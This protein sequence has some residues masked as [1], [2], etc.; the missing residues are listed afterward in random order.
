MNNSFD[1]SRASLIYENCYDLEII[2]RHLSIV[3]PTE[4]LFNLPFKELLGGL[5]NLAT[6]C[7]IS[8]YV[9]EYDDTT[10][11]HVYGYSIVNDGN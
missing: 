8:P 6:M 7:D 11:Y 5:R 9:E 1:Y 4:Q 2:C 3:T 10:P